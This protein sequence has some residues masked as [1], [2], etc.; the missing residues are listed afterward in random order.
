MNEIETA[1]GEDWEKKFDETFPTIYLNYYGYKAN[2]QIKLFIR[3]LIN[4]N[5]LCPTPSILKVKWPEKHIYQ[6]SSRQYPGVRHCKKCS[7]RTSMEDCPHNKTIDLCR[8]AVEEARGERVSVDKIKQEIIK[9]ISK[10]QR[11]EYIDWMEDIKN[12]ATTIHAEVYGEV[13]AKL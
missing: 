1:N 5:T 10:M 6:Y 7:C 4:S 2:D 12:T 13:N 8:K 9:L 11:G 3:Q